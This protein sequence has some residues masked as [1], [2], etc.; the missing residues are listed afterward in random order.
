[1]YT[2]PFETVTNWINSNNYWLPQSIDFLCPHCGR[3][4]NFALNN[5][6]YNNNINTASVNSNCSGC[7]KQVLFF[8]L[9]PVRFGET[10]GQMCEELCI[11]PSPKLD[12]QPMQGLDK[13]PPNVSRAY[14]SAINVFNARE[15]DGTSTLVGRA[16]EGLLK[17]LLPEDKRDLPLGKMLSELP[18]SID[19][20]RTLTTLIDGLRKG[21]NLGAHFDLEKSADEEIARMMIDFLE[22]FLEYLFIIPGEVQELHKRL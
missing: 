13:V 12:R 15:W 10:T 9:S 7:R 19:L 5:W 21:R 3:R 4:V 20:T 1:M 17:T 14:V 11:H 18:N 6:H 22:Y 8:A 16:L 2:I